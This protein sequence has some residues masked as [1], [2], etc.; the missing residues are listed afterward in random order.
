MYIDTNEKP[1]FIMLYRSFAEILLAPGIF[2]G[3][4][5]SISALDS[6]ITRNRPN[7]PARAVAPTTNS[8]SAEDTPCKKA[9]LRW[10][11]VPFPPLRPTTLLS[12]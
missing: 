1:K 5:I 2:P 12:L 6:Q 7:Q 8:G 9:N 11:R 4:C 10:G 3:R